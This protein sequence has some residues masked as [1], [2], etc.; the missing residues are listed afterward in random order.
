MIKPIDIVLSLMDPHADHD[1][2]ILN[3]WNS[4][5][6]EFFMGLDLATNPNLDFGVDRVPALDDE[7]EEPGT[8][9]FAQFYELLMVLAHD[10]PSA[11]DVH[12]MIEET[13]LI[14][15][16]IEWNLWYRRILLKSLH[17]HLPMETIVRNIARLTTE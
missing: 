13:A 3:A 10:K 9:T 4:D 2:T 12:R 1:K 7:D 8:L 6:D 5:S 11:N 16:A 17:K 15:N 14:A